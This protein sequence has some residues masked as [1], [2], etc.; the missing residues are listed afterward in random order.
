MGTKTRKVAQGRTAGSVGEAVGHADVSL[1]RKK[2]VLW[3][4]NFV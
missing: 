4:M 1:L 2:V 3:R